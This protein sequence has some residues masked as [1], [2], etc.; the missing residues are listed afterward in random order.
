MYIYEYIYISICAYMYI[1]ILQCVCIKIHIFGD[2]A[3]VCALQEYLYI[4][5]SIYLRP[6]GPGLSPMPSRPH[7]PPHT[8]QHDCTHA[9]TVCLHIAAVNT[10]RVKCQTP[11]V[12]SWPLQDATACANKHLVPYPT[13]SAVQQAGHFRS[14]GRRGVSPDDV[15]RRLD[16]CRALVLMNF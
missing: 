12:R 6:H 10:S 1:Y 7:G 11:A 9:C 5:I 16:S 13:C 4:Y 15:L 8:P 3:D 2:F 14:F